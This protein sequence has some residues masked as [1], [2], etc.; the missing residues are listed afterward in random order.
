MF[1]SFTELY[2]RANCSLHHCSGPATG[3]VMAS[4]GSEG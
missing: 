2:C 4:S 3:G 1:Y